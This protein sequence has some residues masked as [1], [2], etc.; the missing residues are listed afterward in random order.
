MV[1]SEISDILLFA[2]YFLLLRVKK[3][4]LAITFLMCVLCKL[5]LFD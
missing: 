3:L 2:S 1:S 5:E 4:S